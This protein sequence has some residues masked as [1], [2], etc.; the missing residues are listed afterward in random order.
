NLTAALL[1]FCVLVGACTR[2]PANLAGQWTLRMMPDFAGNQ[3]TEKCT[4]EQQ[5]QR[6]SVRFH[7][8]KG[9]RGGAEMVGVA[10]THHAEWHWESKDDGTRVFFTGDVGNSTTTMA[11]EWRLQFSDGTEL[12]GKFS[13]AKSQ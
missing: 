2:V 4:I 7:N 12:K 5:G 6:L 11:G 9:T 10:A 1:A 3:T 13:G 8:T